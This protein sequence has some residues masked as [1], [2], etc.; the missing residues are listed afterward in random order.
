MGRWPS[1][2]KLGGDV[3]GRGDDAGD[4]KDVGQQRHPR[5]ASSGDIS[6]LPASTVTSARLKRS[7]TRLERR[8]R[9]GEQGGRIREPTNGEKVV[10]SR[11]DFGVH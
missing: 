8:E 4:A 11:Y 3:L 5:Q 7:W 9:R 2:M 10:N 6:Q 1:T